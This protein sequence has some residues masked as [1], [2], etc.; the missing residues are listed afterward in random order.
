MFYLESKFLSLF[1]GG[2]SATAWD[3]SASPRGAALRGA[4]AGRRSVRRAGRA[5]GAGPR[6]GRDGLSGSAR[7]GLLVSLLV[8]WSCFL[9]GEVGLDLS[10][11]MF[12][13]RFLSFAS[14][15]WHFRSRVHILFLDPNLSIICFDSSCILMEACWMMVSLSWWSCWVVLTLLETLASDFF[16]TNSSL[17]CLASCFLCSPACCACSEIRECF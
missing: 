10:I 6:P 3:G 11:S 17:L 9:F 12:S 15:D 1:P 14:S 2:G 5:V 13:F 8:C 7:C 16:M 4:R